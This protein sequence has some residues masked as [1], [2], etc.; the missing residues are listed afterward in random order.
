MEYLDAWKPQTR[1][2]VLRINIPQPII[3]PNRGNSRPSK[4]FVC[5]SALGESQTLKRLMAYALDGC[6]VQPLFSK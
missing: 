6:T 4:V 5:W 2:I 1:L 3:Y